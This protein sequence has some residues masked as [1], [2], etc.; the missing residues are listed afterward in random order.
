L[1]LR[2]VPLVAGTDEVPQ[3]A[4]TLALVLALASVAV[5]IYFI[6]HA[7]ASIQASQ[8]IATAGEELDM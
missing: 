7:A 3:L 5:L 2:E 6:H 1:V 8:I 4:V